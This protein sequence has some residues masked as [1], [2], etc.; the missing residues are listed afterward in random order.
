MVDRSES[1]VHRSTKDTLI[2]AFLAGTI[3]ALAAV[4]AITIG[5]TTGSPLVGV[6]RR[7]SVPAELYR[8]TMRVQRVLQF[9]QAK[10]VAPRDSDDI[11][12]NEPFRSV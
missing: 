5:T 12:G 1:K 4:F 8:R 7:H 3:L 2:R 10:I 6:F 9:Q 11:P